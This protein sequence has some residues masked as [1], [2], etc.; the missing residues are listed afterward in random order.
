MN[1][2]KSFEYI[3]M[4]HILFTRAKESFVDKIC[5]AIF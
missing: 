5:V 1:A 4:T 3:L 2:L